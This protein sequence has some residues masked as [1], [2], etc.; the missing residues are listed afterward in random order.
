MSSELLHGLVQEM[1]HVGSFEDT[2]NLLPSHPTFLIFLFCSLRGKRKLNAK[3]NMEVFKKSLNFKAINILSFSIILYYPLYPK[4]NSIFTLLCLKKWN[5]P[6]SIGGIDGNASTW[7]TCSLCN[8]WRDCLRA[9]YS[10]LLAFDFMTSL[11][12]QYFLLHLHPSC[13]CS[14]FLLI[15]IWVSKNSLSR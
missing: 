4:L 12:Y 11:M 9:S 8:S 10:G 14:F 13:W 15:C 2:E 5:M 3:T 1:F 6:F 7:H